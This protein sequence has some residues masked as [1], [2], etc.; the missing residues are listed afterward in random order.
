MLKKFNNDD[1]LDS[2]I[3]LNTEYNFSSGSNG[4]ISD[5]V[6]LV[7]SS[8]CLYG[9]ARRTQVFVGAEYQKIN[10]IFLENKKRLYPITAS[11]N[12][13][14][15][16]NKDLSLV[17]RSQTTWG[18]N[19]WT[20]IDR[21]Y[22]HYE[23]IN[24][25]YSLNSY[26]HYCIF[27]QRDSKNIISFDGPLTLA[28][29]CFMTGSWVLESWVNPFTTSSLSNNFTIASM[30]RSFWFGIT[31]S[32][33]DVIFSSSEGI[34]TSNQ[35][36]NVGEWSHV[37]LKYNMAGTAS[38][39]INNNFAG[40]F[41]HQTFVT[42]NS[43]SASFSIGSVY[44]G[45]SN[46]ENLEYVAPA[47]F[48]GEPKWSFHGLIGETRFWFNDLS[49]SFISSS[50]NKTIDS[51]SV[52]GTKYCATFK[53]GPNYNFGDIDEIIPYV[54]SG[55][56]NISRFCQGVNTSNF[57]SAFGYFSNFNDRVGPV[58]M[59][60]DN[61]KFFT[62]K[63]FTHINTEYNQFISSSGY[64]NSELSG[65]AS[66]SYI[67]DKKIIKIVNVPS[68]FYGRQI[69]P[70]SVR[71]VCTAHESG[72]WG[73]KR[74]L[75]DDGRGGL[76]LSGSVCALNTTQQSVCWNKVGNVFYNEGLIVIKDETLLDFGIDHGAYN[77]P[78]NTFKL[79]FNGDSRIPYK[80]LNCRIDAGEL[81]CTSNKS[82][83]TISDDFYSKVENIKPRITTIGLFSKEKKLVAVAKL[84]DPLIADDKPKN[85]KIKID[86]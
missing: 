54:G 55:T 22:K 63:Q 35:K 79:T 25:D 13:V 37:M 11:I 26:N 18:K 8:V 5:D 57:A 14:T 86:F 46:P 28:D 85:I 41:V 2:T 29:K 52:S 47:A 9:G 77:S 27:F 56:I 45:S 43:F 44:T 12:Y 19:Y 72:S 38:F 1:I 65:L 59:A 67:E 66:G 34:F 68:I 39:R 42:P 69:L 31:G 17:E 58:W 64:A 6:S 23:T 10:N 73:I 53:E 80:I 78:N 82:F 21:L 32:T 83:V 84:A 24:S 4:W 30:N 49:D 36:I 7:S 61:N 70:H 76:Y 20:S 75:V 48:H 3:I 33:G 16:R 60:S 15:C 50:W 51:T 71:L 40:E 74:T 62:N 81:N